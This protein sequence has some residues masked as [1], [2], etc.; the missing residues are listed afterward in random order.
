MKLFTK[1]AKENEWQTLHTECNKLYNAKGEPVRLV[2]VNC[3]PL[4]WTS[5]VSYLM[6]NVEVACDRWHANT[7]RLPMSQDRWFGFGPEQKGYDESGERYRAEV[8]S[9][10][11]AVAARNKYV[12]LDLH[13]SNV[14]T[15]G[16]FISGGLPDMNSL[17]FW[18]SVAVRYCNHPNV[19]F[20]LY[21]EP[22]QITWDQ[23]KNG[24]EIT[25]YYAQTDIGQQIMFEKSPDT[26]LIPLTYRVP[27]MQ[28]KID[29]VRGVGA[30]N[31]LT[32]GGLD[33]SYELDG[34]VN[35]Y[36]IDDRGGN[37]IILD[38][39]LYPCKAL[40]KWDDYVTV[41]KHKYPILIGEC[42]HY[43]EAPVPHEWPQLEVSTTWV[44]KMLQWVDEH[45]YHITAWHFHDKAGPCLIENMEDYTPTPY[46]GVYFLEFLKKHNAPDRS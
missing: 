26:E 34:I 38:S 8:D 1:Y 10:V 25:V 31:V 40:D 3:G 45:E 9:I 39:H 32:I 16:E 2:G 21:N 22:F 18:K 24:G 19:L 33:W 37:G 28:K 41:A 17:V 13:R 20:D 4:V 6:E 29:T 23:W 27:G 42:G 30:N 5:N 35:G 7:I 43:G 11:E 36:D 14:N 15:W 12:I 46:W 44:P